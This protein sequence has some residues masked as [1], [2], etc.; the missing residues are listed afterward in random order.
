MTLPLCFVSASRDERHACV[1]CRNGQRPLFETPSDKKPVF[2]SPDLSSNDD[3]KTLHSPLQKWS[4]LTSCLHTTSK[5]QS[6]RS[7]LRLQ[8]QSLLCL[9]C[10]P[11]HHTLSPQLPQSRSPP[12]IRPQHLPSRITLCTIRSLRAREPKPHLTSF[13]GMARRTLPILVSGACLR[14]GASVSPLLHSCSA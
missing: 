9:T 6:T 2:F 5:P 14:D 13:H 1:P 12:H 3:Q 4:P 8:E 11:S 7:A 10:L